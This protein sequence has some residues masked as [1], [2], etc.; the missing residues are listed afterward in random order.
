MYVAQKGGIRSD[1]IHHLL[2]QESPDHNPVLD[3]HPVYKN[4][5]IGAGFSGNNSIDLGG[6]V[7]VVPEAEFW[8]LLFIYSLIIVSCRSWL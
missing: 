2:S 7:M 6:Y 4:I 8:V 3:S 5:V 1:S